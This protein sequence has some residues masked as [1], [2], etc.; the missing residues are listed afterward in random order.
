M[1]EIKVKILGQCGTYDGLYKIEV[2]PLELVYGPLNCG[3]T[4]KLVED[5]PNKLP[6]FKGGKIPNKIITST[7]YGV[8]KKARVQFNGNTTILE[9]GDFKTVVKCHEGDKFSYVIGLGLALI[10]YHKKQPSTKK[11]IKFLERCCEYE[12]LAEYCFEKY[13]N[14]DEN[15]IWNFLKNC[16]KGKWINL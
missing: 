14:F 13:F 7:T 10:R 1:K 3:K 9:I 11:D 15:R 2:K 16:N 8:F 5:E 6:G 4:Y 12:N